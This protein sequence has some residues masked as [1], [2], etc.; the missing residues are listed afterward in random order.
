[1]YVHIYIY[2]CIHVYTSFLPFLPPSLPSPPLPFLESSFSSLQIC[3]VSHALVPLLF[4][5]TCP[6]THMYILYVHVCVVVPSLRSA[7]PLRSSFP[8]YLP[9]LASFLHSSHS[10]HC[11]PS[12][13]SFFSIGRI[14]EELLGRNPLFPVSF[15]FPFFLPSFLPSF[16]PTFL[17]T[18]SFLPSLISFLLLPSFLH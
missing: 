4:M 16:L 6:H 15:L 10:F 14:C 9:P 11:L 12:F 13:L 8:R 5:C 7:S 3:Q 2:V 17:P 18:S 1:M